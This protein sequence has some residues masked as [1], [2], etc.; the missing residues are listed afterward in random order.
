MSILIVEDNATNAL[1]LKHLAKKVSDAEIVIE[2]DPIKALERCHNDDFDML[3]LDHLLPGMSGIQLAKAVRMIA[4]YDGVPIIMVTAD[5]APDLK[6]EAER[7]GI[8]DFLTKPVEA[9]AFRQLVMNHLQHSP[10][11]KRAAV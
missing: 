4:R 3:I 6:L 10:L 11:L 1:I 7:A 5:H 9:L 2:A 8:N